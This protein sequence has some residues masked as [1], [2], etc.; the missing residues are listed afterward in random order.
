MSKTV[1]YSASN[2]YDTL[3]TLSE[4]T[5]NVWLVCHGIG[6]LSRQF[7][8]FFKH[9]DPEKNY[10][11]APQAPSK[12]YKNGSYK[13]VGACWLTKENTRIETQNVLQYLDAI[14]TNEN[15]PKTVSFTVLG[16]SQGVSI[17]SRWVSS[18]K[19]TCTNLILISGILPKELHAQDFQFLAETTNVIY[20]TGRNDPYFKTL[21]IDVQLKQLQ[22]VFPK[23][24]FRIHDGGHEIE[25]STFRDLH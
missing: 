10:I 13:T 14:V 23:I 22:S 2:T 3:N 6:Y 7:I 25:R 9:L 21:P 20:I 15:L 11:I 1:S 8:L 24:D 17:A 19:I 18:R 5:E 4:K 12:Y 16:Y